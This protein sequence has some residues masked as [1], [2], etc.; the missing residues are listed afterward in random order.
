[1]KGILDKVEESLDFQLKEMNL[2]LQ[3][4]GRCFSP[5]SKIEHASAFLYWTEGPI[6]HFNLLP[7]R[8]CAQQRAC[9]RSCEN[10]SLAFIVWRMI[11][12]TPGSIKILVALAII[13]WPQ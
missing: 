1:M 6:K 10:V 2:R 11:Q 13:K 8:I 9:V 5:L 7:H 3:R 4:L 12:V